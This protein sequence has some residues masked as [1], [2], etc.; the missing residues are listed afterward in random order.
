[1]GRRIRRDGNRMGGSVL[2]S[3]LNHVRFGVGYYLPVT[4]LLD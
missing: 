3:G 4:S 1:M 2:Y